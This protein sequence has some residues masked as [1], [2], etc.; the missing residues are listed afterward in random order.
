MT[1]C[2]HRCAI[3]RSIC[4]KPG[5]SFGRK[6][7]TVCAMKFWKIKGV[8]RGMYKRGSLL[9]RRWLAMR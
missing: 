3:K 5:G 9:K 8:F 4:I 7:E 6:T 2:A 1:I